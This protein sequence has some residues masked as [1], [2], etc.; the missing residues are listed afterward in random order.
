VSLYT[1][2]LQVAQ[3]AKSLDMYAIQSWL[4]SFNTLLSL[5]FNPILV[6]GTARDV[7]FM[8]DFLPSYLFPHEESKIDSWGVAGISLGGHSTWIILSQGI[9]PIY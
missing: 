8:I 2:I 6:A 9:V 7:S 1:F 5:C 3:S 4:L